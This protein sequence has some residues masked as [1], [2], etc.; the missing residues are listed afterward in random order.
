MNKKMK[1]V[2]IFSHLDNERAPICLTECIQNPEVHLKTSLY[3]SVLL[4]LYISSTKFMPLVKY[5]SSPTLSSFNLLQSAAS[6]SVGGV[7]SVTVVV[8]VESSP[9]PW[10]R[11]P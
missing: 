9:N 10:Q 3:R 2:K 7:T 8:L 1:I 5:F 4:Y 6:S 11:I